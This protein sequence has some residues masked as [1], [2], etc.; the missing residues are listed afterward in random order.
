[1]Q[2]GRLPSRCFQL[3]QFTQGPLFGM[4][5]PVKSRNGQNS[6][7]F[8]ISGSTRTLSSMTVMHHRNNPSFTEHKCRSVTVAIIHSDN[9]TLLLQR[10]V[11]SDRPLYSFCEIF[12]LS[13]SCVIASGAVPKAFLITALSI[14]I[15][16]AW[17][18]KFMSQI[19]PPLPKHQTANWTL[20]SQIDNRPPTRRC[21][22]TRQWRAN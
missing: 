3:L 6:Y 11:T 9:R 22:S 10:V 12:G 4:H 20:D 1:M 16:T 14:E 19:S 13:V 5:D 7:R 18:F 15:R 2:L 21:Q 8:V 17:R